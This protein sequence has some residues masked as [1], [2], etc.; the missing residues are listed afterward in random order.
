MI[1]TLSLR[2]IPEIYISAWVMIGKNPKNPKT[3]MLIMDS[4][5]SFYG[6]LV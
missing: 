5:K 3:G 6:F 4:Q 2:S 1:S